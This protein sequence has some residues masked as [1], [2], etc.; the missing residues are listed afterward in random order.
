MDPYHWDDPND[1][2][3]DINWASMYLLF[4]CAFAWLGACKTIDITA[5]LARHAM[6]GIRRQR[7]H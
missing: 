4:G 5:R 2:A 7:G 1:D 3:E 6:R